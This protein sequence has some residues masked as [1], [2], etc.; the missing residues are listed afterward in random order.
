MFNVFDGY[1][2]C[3][4]E[5]IAWNSTAELA[6]LMCNDGYPAGAVNDPSCRVGSD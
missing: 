5:V 1:K 3:V 2:P 4:G 6:Q